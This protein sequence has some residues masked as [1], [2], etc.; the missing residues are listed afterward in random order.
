MK[1]LAIL[2]NGGDTCALNASIKSIRDNAYRAGF[3]KIYGI[4]RGYQGLV[5]GWIDDI[6]H[7]E[8]DPRIGGS[9]LGSLRTSPTERV[10]DG[11]YVVVG[12]RCRVMAQ[13]LS[14]YR[15]DVLVVIG[16]D[17]T[18]QSTRMFQAWVGDILVSNARLGCHVEQHGATPARMRTFAIPASG[19]PEMLWYGHT[20]G[21]NNLLSFPV[22][23]EI[24]V[25]SRPGF[26]TLTFSVPEEL[27][28]SKLESRGNTNTE[29]KLTPI[30]QVFTANEKL[31]N[32]LRYT[33]G[34]LVPQL[35]KSEGD[36]NSIAAEIQEHI[37][38]TLIQ[39]LN[40][41]GADEIHAHHKSALLEQVIDHIQSHP[42]A[43]APLL[44]SN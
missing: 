32:K 30:E 19:T 41:S 8:I 3:K 44:V 28:L 33:L 40:E 35:A 9:C 18:L 43:E 11:K 31:L 22:H 2:T 23:G 13:C 16:G 6:T 1:T 17:G 15:I 14:D 42:H 39:I 27:L 37:L 7:R 20:I 25:F 21:P 36:H 24:D 38:S 4:R 34:V 12:E 5:D 26:H 10:E 29:K